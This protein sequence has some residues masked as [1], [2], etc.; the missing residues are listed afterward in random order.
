MLLKELVEADGVSGNE[1]AVRDVLIRAIAEVTDEYCVDA[2][3]N[4]LAVKSAVGTSTQAPQRVMIVAHMDE[5]GLMVTKVERDGFVR[6]APVGG[7][8][9][10][11]LLGKAVR[12][13]PNRV[14]GVIGVKPIHRLDANERKRVLPIDQLSIDTG[15]GD[16]ASKTIKP[17]MY[18]AFAT[19]YGELG[20][21]PWRTVKAKALDDRLGCA[22]LV[23]LL[24]GEYPFEL[25]AAFTAQEEV[26]LRGARVAAYAAQ[27]DVALVL[28]GTVCDDGPKDRDVTPTTRLGDGPAITIMDRSVIC[29]SR[30]VRLVLATAEAEGIPHQIKQPGI[31]GT[32]GGAIHL[33]RDG[34]P[35]S[36]VAVPVRYIHSPVS[37]ASLVDMERTVQLVRS[38]LHR[39]QGG[40][41][42]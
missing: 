23:E 22:V 36:V 39:L 10:R 3:G 37:V 18:V 31:G 27:P 32:D 35:T 5:V 41:G 24:R 25:I 11:V 7:I 2:L 21:D 38:T 15:L 13:G 6:F 14:P 34:V 28:E 8:D 12:I 30:L 9:P 1:Q 17:G 4:L 33:Q 26:G 42:S 20:D 19:D 16:E 29:D 40:W